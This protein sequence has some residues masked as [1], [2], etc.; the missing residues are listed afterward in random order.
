MRGGRVGVVGGSIAGCAVALAA[1]RGN[2][3]ETVVFERASGKLRERGAGLV[4]NLDRYAELKAAGFVD[5]RMPSAAVRTRR[6]FARGGGSA[7]GRE[8]ANVP[9]HAR[10]YNW[11]SLWHEL[12]RRIPG[13]VEY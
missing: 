4:V 3:G 7:L 13:A 10:A 8:V 11:G 5:D 9:F 12:R 2:A 6:W 1:A